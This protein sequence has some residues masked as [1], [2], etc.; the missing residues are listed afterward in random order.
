MSLNNLNFL[1]RSN[2]VILPTNMSTSICVPG[3][4]Y[5]H[6]YMYMKVHPQRWSKDN[7]CIH[8]LE[9]ITFVMS[10][11]LM[12][13]T[14]WVRAYCPPF[15][16]EETRHRKMQKL[17]RSHSDSKGCWNSKLPRCLSG[18]HWDFTVHRVKQKKKK[19]L[20][21]STSLSNLCYFALF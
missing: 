10:T 14:L 16:N 2:N 15:I 6:I 4:M 7:I 5:S 17:P 21:S 20:P 8:I 18:C 9:A 3:F 12:L 19:R 11:H 1:W 13:T